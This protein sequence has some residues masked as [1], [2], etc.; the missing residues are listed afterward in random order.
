[1]SDVPVSAPIRSSS[2][3]P[4]SVFFGLAHRLSAQGWRL[5]A[6]PSKARCSGSGICQSASTVVVKHSRWQFNLLR[7]ITAYLGPANHDLSRVTFDVRDC[8]TI[9]D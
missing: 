3:A 8:C 5:V 1:M 9:Y 6:L 4:S 7:C 2:C